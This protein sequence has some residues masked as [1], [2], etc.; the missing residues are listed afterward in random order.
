MRVFLNVEG[1]SQY[2][3]GVRPEFRNSAC[4]PTTAFVILKYLCTDHPMAKKDVNDLYK[5]LGGTKIG[6]FKWRLI[7][8]LRRVL[9]LSFCIESCNLTEALEQLRNGHPVAMKFD[10]YF[11]FQ[12]FLKNKPLFK[13]HWVPLIGYEIKNNELYLI[14]HDNGGQ[15]RESEIRSFR[16]E[17]N[18]KVLSFVKIEP[19]Q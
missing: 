4:G 18:R 15:N 6:L 9:S 1:M 12:W 11:T 8:N 3:E 5:I 19:K 7:K 16:Y 14:I 13:Y 2:S 17:D 10:Q